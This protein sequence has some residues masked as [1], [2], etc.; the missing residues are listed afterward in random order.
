MEWIE[1]ETGRTLPRPEC[2]GRN[3]I[4][5]PTAEPIEVVRGAT[6]G[7]RIDPHDP[8]DRQHHT[9][10]IVEPPAHGLA[11]VDPDGAVYYLAPDVFVGDD[12]VTIEVTDDGEP[13]LSAR[14]EIPIRVTLG[15]PV[16]DPKGCATAPFGGGW[17]ALAALGWTRRRRPC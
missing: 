9:F 1:A 4:P 8:D 7:A 10:A 2:D 17:L 3:R 15:Q 13:P 6:G 11:Q 5:S 14:V 16:A 12:A